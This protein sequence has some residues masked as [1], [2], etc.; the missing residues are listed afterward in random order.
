MRHR[1]ESPLGIVFRGRR[2]DLA[3]AY[4]T[5]YLQNRSVPIGI[6]DFS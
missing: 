3:K 4:G 1:D 5:P 2:I 6:D